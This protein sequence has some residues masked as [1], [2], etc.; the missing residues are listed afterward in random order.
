MS[1]SFVDFNF[2]GT[3]ITIESIES[4]YILNNLLNDGGVKVYDESAVRVLRTQ[5]N[6]LK[7]EQ[8]LT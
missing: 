5:L 3:Y 6:E 7:K 1:A 4:N 2:I 8:S